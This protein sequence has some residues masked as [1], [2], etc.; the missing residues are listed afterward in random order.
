MTRLPWV[1]GFVVPFALASSWPLSAS[2]G[3]VD[4]AA[5]ARA[6]YQQG[7]Q[8][9][10][11][12]RYA[13]AATHFESAASFRPHAVALYTAA[14]AWDLAGNPPRAADAYVRALEVPGLDPKQTATAKERVA[15][16]E[17]TLGTMAVSGV[18]GS[19]AR[20]DDA[21]EVAVPARLHGTAGEHGLYV[22]LP[23]KEPERTA[24]LLEAGKVSPFEVVEKAAPPEPVAEPTAPEPPPSI[25][26]AA[27]RRDGHFWTLRRTGGA[28]ATGVGLAALG[29]TVI[30]GVS[31][32]GARDAYAA[33]PTREGFDH[34]SSLQTWTNV[35]WV[36]GALLVAGGVTLIVLPDHDGEARVTAA[37]GPSGGV[38]RG[39]F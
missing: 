3:D 32:N 10:Q 33:A 21:V 29:S 6:Q 24:V 16:L 22:R 13:E 5:E 36:A 27:P 1:L 26:P 9:F 38:V 18:P 4:S 19:L 37:L 34:A 2:A 39:R 17:K 31:A 7:T 11:A 23:G 25:E 20:L 12:K 15:Q 14:L 35:S 30:L 8:A 28:F